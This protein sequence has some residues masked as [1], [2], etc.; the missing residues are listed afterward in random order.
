MNQNAGWSKGMARPV[1]E[2]GWRRVHSGLWR[3]ILSL[4]A[5][6]YLGM[7]GAAWAAVRTA[8]GAGGCNFTTAAAALANCTTGSDVVSLTGPVTETAAL[9]IPQGAS[10]VTI[11]GGNDLTKPQSLVINTASWSVYTQYNGTNSINFQN[12]IFYHKVAVTSSPMFSNNYGGTFTFTNCQ[13]ISP[14]TD[15]LASLGYETN[16][17]TNCIFDG[18]NKATAGVYSPIGNGYAV[19]FINCIIRNVAGWGFN[20]GGNPQVV[21][22]YNSDI[23]NNSNGV[24]FNT[25]W[26]NAQAVTNCILI[27]N[28]VDYASNCCGGNQSFTNCVFKTAPTPISG[29]LTL[30]NN[31]TS[32][33]A[34]EFVSPYSDLHLLSTAKSIGTG[35][36]LY[37]VVSGLNSDIEG[38]ARPSSGAWDVGAYIKPTATPTPTRTPTPAITP[39][40]T[41]TATWTKTYTP[42][43]TYTK[44]YT[45]IYSY[46][47]TKTPVPTNTFTLTL[48]PTNTLSPTKT[49]TPQFT[50]TKTY[51][52]TPTPTVPSYPTNTFTPTWT[53]SPTS[54]GT[55]PPNT[56]LPATCRLYDLEYIP[57]PVTT[58]QFAGDVELSAA[59][60][61]IPKN[62]ARWIIHMRLKTNPTDSQ[63]TTIGYHIIETRMGTVPGKHGAVGGTVGEWDASGAARVTLGNDL[64]TYA[65]GVTTDLQNLS[66]TYVWVGARA[67][68]SEHYQF[69]GDARYCPYQDVKAANGYNWYFGG[70][71]TA[72]TGYSGFDKAQTAT[73]AMGWSGTGGNVG[74]EIAGA[75]Y[76][77]ARY[78]ELYRQALLNTQG[79]ISFLNGWTC[80]YTG[81]GGEMGCDISPFKTGLNF[82][83]RPWKHT[84]GSTSVVNEIASWNGTVQASRLISKYISGT[85]DSGWHSAP[86]IGDLFPD[87]FYEKCWK[88]GAATQT[89]G[90]NLP[91]VTSGGSP[92]TFYR[93]PWNETAILPATSNGITIKFPFTGLSRLP[94]SVLGRPGCPSLFLGN[95][96]SGSTTMQTQHGDGE[97]TVTA[98]SL[99]TNLGL[100]FNYP[101]PYQLNINR[102]FGTSVTPPFPISEWADS[103]YSHTTVSV[104]SINSTPCVF[105]PGNTTTGETKYSVATLQVSRGS[106]NFFAILNGSKPSGDAGP[107][108]LG[109]MVLIQLM[110]GFF[111]GGMLTGNSHVVQLPLVTMLSPQNSGVVN[112][113]SGTMPVTWQSA[114]T[115]WGGNRYT[116]QYSA[117]FSE[118]VSMTYVLLYNDGS[119]TNG[120]L[121]WW[122]VLSPQDRDYAPGILPQKG[123]YLPSGTLTDDVLLS[124]T[125]YN[126]DISSLP[127]GTYSLRIEGYRNDYNQNYTYHEVRF[128]LT[129]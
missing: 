28:G 16:V 63:G 53:G 6:I 9:M 58:D 47:F 83:D 38:N 77:V 107:S 118:S 80:Y 108:E 97:A 54:T 49:N 67:P 52:P 41:V 123:T 91:L 33:G 34:A 122:Y 74:S 84:V 99:G 25:A 72:W 43:Y 30:T 8:C 44:T 37:G 81:F 68:E 5:V 2:Q 112:G 26:Y 15:S 86:W 98:T 59:G 55:P 114:W 121:K 95:D 69:L 31:L 14:V 117:S 96:G 32:T 56:G 70:S 128:T 42:V 17:F 102:P 71:S 62:T 92:T 106:K 7:G 3:G 76:D 10:G 46:T 100:M 45:P 75:P 113:S 66:R 64:V 61:G 88:Q 78:H 105:Y 19:T 18:L 101:V 120:E 79:F 115:R 1:A 73:T 13:F 57:C 29:Q 51:S 103:T 111:D 82:V 21:Y 109:S 11:T 40:F 110:R 36:N 126:W 12:I 24:S 23:V 89:V 119:S 22:M 127:A 35:V 124:T 129:K 87:D 104:P 65:E 50:Y 125:G 4:A 94:W 27:N 85:S 93:A 90:G 116:E 60:T 20:Q 48:V 39:T